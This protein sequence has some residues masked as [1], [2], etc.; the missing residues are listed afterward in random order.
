MLA[1]RVTHHLQKLI[2]KYPAIYK[3]FIP[4]KQELN[5]HKGC[6]DP[7]LEEKYTVTRGLIHKYPNRA[8][9]L[10]TL[11]C[12]AYCRFCSRRRTVSEIEKGILTNRDLDNI[13]RYLIKHPKIEELIFSGGDPLTTPLPLEQALRKFC[14]LPQIKIIRVGTRLHVSD[15]KKIDN[16]V[17]SALKIVKRQ[18]LYLMVHFEHP[19]EITKQTIKAVQKLQTVS[20][21]LLSQTVFLKGINDSIEI[22]CNLFTRLIE[23]GVKP[24]YLLRCDKVRGAKHFIVDLKKE[25]IILSKLRRCL[26]GIACPIF[27]KDSY[28]RGSKKVIL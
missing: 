10:L 1:V 12:A 22:L 14:R 8:L 11:N 19:T 28:D 23:I 25:K 5:C 15:P 16:K 2:K 24:Y 7:L 17:L 26:S 6:D 18:P 9:V 3:Q 27:V 20:T 13:E 4:S 21:M